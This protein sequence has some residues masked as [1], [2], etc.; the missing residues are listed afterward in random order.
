MTPAEITLVQE[1]FRKLQ[2][3]AEQA[4]ALFYAR[5]FELDPQLRSLFRGDMADQGRKLMAMLGV[6]VA[7]L[8][9]IEAIAPTVRQLGARH[10]GYGVR[11]EHYSTV[12]AALLW[13][14]EKGLGA[15]FTAAV[16]DAWT[17]TYTLLANTM[18]DAQRT[19][20]DAPRKFRVEIAA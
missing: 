19:G 18:I 4:A 7:A 8:D 10:A 14:L 9:R 17:N 2:P 15:E 1:S 3:I 20:G 13:T 5:L 6:A 11:E 12:G 16:R